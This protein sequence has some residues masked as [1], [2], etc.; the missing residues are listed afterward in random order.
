VTPAGDALLIQPAARPEP[1]SARK[2]APAADNSDRVSFAD[3]LDAETDAASDAT[4][5]AAAQPAQP[6][7]A[8]QTTALGSILAALQTEPAPSAANAA[9]TESAPTTDGSVAPDASALIA[10]PTQSN[11]AATQAALVAAVTPKAAPA[12]SAM[13]PD[14]GAAKDETGKADASAN[15]A[16]V[17]NAA[18]DALLSLVAA[19]DAAEAAPAADMLAATAISTTATNAAPAAP[20]TAAAKDDAALVVD[21][22]SSNTSTSADDGKTIPPAATTTAS[23]QKVGVQTNAQAEAASAGGSALDAKVDGAQAAATTSTTTSTSMADALTAR[24][25]TTETGAAK[26]APALANAPAAVAQV[27]TR[28]IE[29]HDGRAQRFE[30]RLDPVELGQVDVRIEVGADKKVHAVLAAHDSAALGDLMKGQRALEQAL[31]DAGIDLADGGLKFELSSNSGRDL[32]GNPQQNEAGYGR[33]PSNVWRGF[34]ALD[35]PVDT[36]A[37]DLAGATRIYRRA[38]ARLDVMA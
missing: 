14:D 31:S 26:P 17:S 38:A 6:A 25:Q 7:A 5:P 3:V 18:T 15:A 11:P 36:N 1:A 19:P 21:A 16:G 24:G 9:S 32:A 22:S 27:Y 4:P 33:E 2:D 12:T 20:K 37:A 34:S 13:A 30:I 28:F 10:Q 8:P 35:I 23:A 29:R